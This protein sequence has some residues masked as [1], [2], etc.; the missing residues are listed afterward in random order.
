MATSACKTILLDN[1]ELTLAY[2]NH[3]LQLSPYKCLAIMDG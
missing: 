3:A 1:K 2:L